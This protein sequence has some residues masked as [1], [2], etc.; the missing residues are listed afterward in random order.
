MATEN[1]M[2]GLVTTGLEA[3]V[4]LMVRSSN[5]SF[6]TLDFIVDTGF[7]GTLSLSGTVISRLGLQQVQ[8]T[9]IQL[10]DGS[11]QIC[12]VY[13]LEVEWDGV[14]QPR[15]V[16]DIGGETLIGVGMLVR[17]TLCIT[18]VPGGSVSITPLP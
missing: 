11:H 13:L 15:R 8:R 6:D 9:S 10:A 7:T 4:S 3:V 18:Y 16:I 12:P 17:N 14:W 5:G 2:L 1:E